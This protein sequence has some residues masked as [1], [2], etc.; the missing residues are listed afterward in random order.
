MKHVILLGDSIRLGYRPR[1]EADL[2]DGWLIHSPQSNGGTTRRTLAHFEAWVAEP[3][4]AVGPD[5]LIL[6]VNCGLHDLAYKREDQDQAVADSPDVPPA[7]YRENVRALLERAINEVGIEASRIIWATTTPVV[8]QLHNTQKPFLRRMADV[9]AYN[10]AAT[11]EAAALG[12]RINDLHT[13]VEAAGGRSLMT[14]DGVH[15]TAAG[16]AHLGKAVAHAIRAADA[17]R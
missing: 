1:V 7:E 4:R 9:L 10:R 3:A 17:G 13:V 16:S 5:G 11:E 15:Y 2:G 14:D 8:E 12:C 6:H